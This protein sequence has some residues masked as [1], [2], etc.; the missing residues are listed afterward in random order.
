[1]KVSSSFEPGLK[2]TTELYRNLYS[3][4]LCSIFSSLC[5]IKIFK[6]LV[7]IF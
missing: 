5:S 3:M 1:M 7:N 2:L 4:K 6:E